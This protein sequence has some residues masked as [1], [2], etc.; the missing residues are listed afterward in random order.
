MYAEKLQAIL[1][2]PSAQK[3][4]KAIKNEADIAGAVRRLRRMVP[5][6][7]RWCVSPERI[8][9]FIRRALA[10]LETAATPPA[11]T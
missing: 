2:S 11:K 10:K 8:E 6:P 4:I 9:R 5:L 3:I 7:W 1:A